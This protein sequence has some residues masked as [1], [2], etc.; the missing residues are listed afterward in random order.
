MKLINAEEL[1]LQENKAKEIASIYVPMVKMLEDMEGQFNELVK[2][3][4]ITEELVKDAKRLRLDIRTV[5]LNADKARKSAKDEYL[6]AGNAIQGAYN[7]LKFAVESKEEKLMAIEQHFENIEKERVEKLRLSREQELRDYGVEFFPTGL[8]EMEDI[9]WS[10]FLKGTKVSYEAKR[11]IE[12]QA[13]EARLEEERKAKLYRSRKNE[14]IEFWA[15]LKNDHKSVNFGSLSQESFDIILKE[16][17]DAKVEHEADQKRIREDNEKLQKQNKEHAKRAENERVKRQ[18]EQDELQ[19][20]NDKLE[21]EAEAKREEEQKAQEQKEADAEAKLNAGDKEKLE[22]LKDNI[23][24]ITEAFK[25]KSKKNKALYENVCD[26]L[27][28]ILT[29]LG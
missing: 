29:K 27:N 6:K 3:D 28:N 21:E 20:K 11:E 4:E 17:K 9:V 2:H 8:G 13:E 15:F 26:D 16:V 19:A 18:K 5:R 22:I 14:L 7:T 23:F 25:F 1:G 24:A 12:K 10:N